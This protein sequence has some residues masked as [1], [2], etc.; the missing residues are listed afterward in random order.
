MQD[1]ETEEQQLEAIKNWWKRNSGSL[2]IGLAIG[3]FSLGGWNFYQ[4]EQFDH[5]VEASDMY[6]TVVAQAA[7]GTGAVLESTEVDKLEA[8]YSD[9]PYAALSALVVANYEIGVGNVEQAMS[10][11]QWAMANAVDEEVSYVAQLRLARL[12]LDQKQFDEA[13]KLLSSEHPA[14]FEALLEE[15]KGDMYAAKGE[16][17][18]ARIAYDKAIERSGSS[19]RWLQLKRQNLGPSKLN[20]S[21]L[22]D[23]SA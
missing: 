9:T 17:D 1:F 21:E 10:K 2:F 13:N 3:G 23:P 4:Q 16:R 12:M 15:L 5:S 22:A 7:A 6:V 18:Q 11:L 8:G 14:A 20:Q 19:S